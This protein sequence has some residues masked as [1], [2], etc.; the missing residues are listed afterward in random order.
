MAKRGKLKSYAF[1]KGKGNDCPK[2]K[3]PMQRRARKKPPANKT[4]F[5][6]EWDYCPNCSHIQHYDEFKSSDWKEAEYNNNRFQML[7]SDD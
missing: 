4:Y 2:C 7:I 3:I 1:V 6:T 5:F